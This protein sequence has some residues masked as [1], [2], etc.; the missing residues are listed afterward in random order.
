MVDEHGITDEEWEEVILQ[1]QINQR[2]FDIDEDEDIDL[3]LVDFDLEQA[4]NDY[5]ARIRQQQEQC[6][7]PEVKDDYCFLCNKYFD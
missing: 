6:T 3:V 2:E 7:H 4:Y 5:Y 1:E